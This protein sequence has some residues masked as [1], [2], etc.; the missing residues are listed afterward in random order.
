MAS[1][2]LTQFAGLMPQL[3][4]KLKRKD[5]AQIAHNC[6]L[7]DGRLQAMPA[8]YRYQQ[9]TQA[10]ISLYKAHIFPP[11][12]PPGDIVPEFE[13][14]NAV[15]F[16]GPPFP[17]GTIGV[18]EA[19]DAAYT[20]YLA[21][22]FGSPAITGN[23]LP[24]GIGPIV[25]TAPATFA[26]TAMHMSARPTVI[27]YAITAIRINGNNIEETPPLYLGTVGATNP[28]YYDGDAV[29]INVQLQVFTCG[30]AAIR[31]Y[32]SIT[33]IET[34][35]QLVNTFDTDWYLLDTIPIN[36][37]APVVSYTDVVVSQ[38]LKGTLLLSE[39]YL[40]PFFRNP[41]RDFGLTESGWLWFSTK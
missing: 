36:P 3:S 2:R 28:L 8:Y 38:N 33:A 17:T 4:A 29:Q 27:A 30:E 9:L 12:N 7:Y 15:Y 16:D 19:S 22:K 5:N 24:A 20:T 26:L 6:L 11:F 23:V 37:A 41:P 25:A 21:V 32:R 39:G 10:P 40:P 18:Y 35:E 14:L 13:L 34:G 1:I 31:I